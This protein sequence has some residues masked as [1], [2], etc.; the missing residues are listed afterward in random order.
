MGLIQDIEDSLAQGEIKAIT[1][2]KSHDGSIQVSIRRRRSYGWNVYYGTELIEVLG[3]AVEGGS[4]LPTVE[5]AAL[6]R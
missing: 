4:Q 2:G 6:W 5:Q 3:R 1:V